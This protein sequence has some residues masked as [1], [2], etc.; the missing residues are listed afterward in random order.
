MNKWIVAFVVMLGIA[1]SSLSVAAE[2]D[3]KNPY[4]LINSVADNAFS[5]LKADKE[6]YIANPELLRDVVKQELMPYINVR[7][8][9]LKVLGPQARKASKEERDLF[10]EAF[11]DY[12]VASYAQILTQYT[13]QEIVVEQEKE[14]DDKRKVVSVRVDILDKA[15]PPIRLDFALRKNGKTEE[16]QGFDVQV[17]G[18]SMLDTKTSEWSGELRKNGIEAVAKQLIERAKAPITREGSES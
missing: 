17:E 8:A 9:A 6:Q 2:I 14:I 13:D 4:T 10:T 3:A 12:L 11:Y 16:W 1:F 15:R 5:R 7:Y 18:V